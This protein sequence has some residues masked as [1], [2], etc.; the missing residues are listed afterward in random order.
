MSVSVTRVFDLLQYNLENFPK[1]D[2]FNS[3]INGVWEKYSTQRLSDT[4]DRL[5]RGLIGLGMAKGSKV[6][7]MSHNRP[8]WN[9]TD[10]AIIQI[11]ALQVPLYPTLAE[12]DIKFILENA[13]VSIIFLADEALY[14][15]VKAVTEA[16]DIPVR[17][18]TFDQVPGAEN[19]L[20]LV[21]AG[22]VIKRLTCSLIVMRL[23]RKM[24]LP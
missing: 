13:E 1:D 5:S 6:A 22:A 11:G 8:E 10:F 17:L 2:L 19:W 23:A 16:N 9:I 7:V 4:V 14:N 21:E 18:Y 3:K 12:H 15:K 20:D 24:C